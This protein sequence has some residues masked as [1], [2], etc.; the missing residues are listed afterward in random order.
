[1]NSGEN[2]VLT[3]DRVKALLRD[4]GIPTTDFSV[5]KSPEDLK[6]IEME[7]PVALKVCSSD[8]LHKTDVGGVRLNIMDMEEL[9]DELSNFM[10]KFPGEKFIVEKMEPQ[11][12]EM[13]AGLVNDPSFGMS[14][15]VGMGGIFAEI[16][17]DVSFRLAP[18][19][20]RDAEE[21][22]DEL[23]AGELFSGFRGMELDRKAMVDMLLKLSN[24]GMDFPSINQMD[25]NPVFVY[26]D[27]IKVVDAKMIK[28]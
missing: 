2:R 1:M 23:E 11:G 13:I 28:N 4:Y 6:G 7:F 18:I 8:I 26:A 10:K 25:L 22:I 12:V 5:L 19:K 17:K 14:I 24:I 15:M 20:E 27:G 21:M 16:Y 3:E 9:E